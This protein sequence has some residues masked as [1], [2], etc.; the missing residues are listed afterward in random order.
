M[1]LWSTYYIEG[2]SGFQK[3]PT[4]SLFRV[5]DLWQKQSTRKRN[6]TDW[7][8]C[9]REKH[10]VSFQI[11]KTCC[12]SSFWDI[13]AT[14][15]NKRRWPFDKNHTTPKPVCSANPFHPPAH[16]EGEGAVWVTEGR[17]GPS[18]MAPMSGM[19]GKVIKRQGGTSLRFSL[20]NYFWLIWS[21]R[22][23]KVPSDGDFATV[24]RIVLLEISHTHKSPSIFSIR[25]YL[26]MRSIAPGHLKPRLC[27]CFFH[28]PTSEALLTLSSNFPWL[29]NIH[30]SGKT[31]K[32]RGGDKLIGSRNGVL[33]ILS[34]ND[35]DYQ[36]Q[37]LWIWS[38]QFSFCF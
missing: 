33:P 34:R 2:T 38:S 6:S 37:M 29:H 10:Y 24:L 31:K 11:F 16:L 8:V 25:P 22:L 18:Q 27:Y 23:P 14:V 36:E 4:V 32:K 9:K 3:Y 13:N 35:P 20:S 7:S 26:W 12:T 28:S 17:N 21:Y 30:R 15:K 5:P 19:G 1:Y